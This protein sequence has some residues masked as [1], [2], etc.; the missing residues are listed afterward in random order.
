[1]EASTGSLEVAVS[2]QGC[3]RSG[4]ALPYVSLVLHGFRDLEE[5]C[6]V[7][8]N[9]EGWDLLGGDLSGSVDALLVAIGHDLK[10]TAV[11]LLSGPL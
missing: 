6:T 11:D 7:G 4:G 1:M 2:P 8:A 10:K 5:S 9:D 3:R